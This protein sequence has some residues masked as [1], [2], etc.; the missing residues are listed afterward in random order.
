MYSEDE[1]LAL[2][3]ALMCTLVGWCPFFWQAV[4]IRGERHPTGVRL[5]LFLGLA[6][7]GGLL[8]VV[9]T[10]WSAHDVRD[11]TPYLG[12]YAVL[13]AGWLGLV[14]P[15]LDYLDLRL[16]DDVLERG[17]PA[18]SWA[19]GGAMLGLMACFAGG[20]IGD[21]PGWW[22]VIY[23][24]MLATGTAFLSWIALD[25]CTGIADTISIGRDVAAGVRAAGFWIGLGLIL[26]R[27]AAGNWVS[28]EAA[29]I[30]FLTYG[31]PAL[32][33]LA[34]AIGIEREFRPEGSFAKA[35]LL[36]QGVLPAA[37]YVGEGVA[38]LYLF[39]A[40]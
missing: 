26:G 23:S 35:P 38:D 40:P 15:I 24:A 21:G 14:R 16:R 3:I 20:N 9:L 28:F 6:A 22:V 7:A 10:R 31:W 34:V 2:M 25:L 37:L 17:N 5:P 33:L 32:G 11:S 12:F 19:G 1:I 29:N 13:G 39:G 30:D 4:W 18:S 8:Y 27:A 36:L